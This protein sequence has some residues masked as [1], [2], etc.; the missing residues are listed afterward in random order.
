M[1]HSSQAIAQT[2]TQMLDARAATSSICPSEVA[3]KLE[4]EESA[5]RAL[6]PAVREVA[7]DMQDQG[8]LRITRGEQ[9]VTRQ[10]LHEGPIRLRRTQPS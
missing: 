6:M 1:K 10:D 8:R 2:I 7:A 9:P 5:W 4:H 3:R